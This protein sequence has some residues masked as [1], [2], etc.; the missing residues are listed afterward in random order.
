[1]VMRLLVKKKGSY[2][3]L[4]DFRW[5]KVDLSD[6]AQFL[7]LHVFVLFFIENLQK[8]SKN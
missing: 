4:T 3:S 5:F 2:M 1:M 8:V 6:Y 7:Y